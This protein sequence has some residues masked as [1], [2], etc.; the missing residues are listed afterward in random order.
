MND[1]KKL[2]LDN[3]MRSKNSPFNRTSTAA[4]QVNPNASEINPNSVSYSRLQTSARIF[5]AV[6]SLGGENV[7]T[8]GDIQVAINYASANGGGVV[9]LKAGTYVLT[10]N[11]TLT[12]NVTLLGEDRESTIISFGNA[13]SY[14]IV[15]KGTST[16]D[17]ITNVRLESLQIANFGTS[18]GS[19]GSAP[20]LIDYADNVK[21]VHCKFKT[22]YATVQT[23]ATVFASPHISSTIIVTDSVFDTCRQGVKISADPT[24]FLSKGNAIYVTGNTFT[25]ITEHCV[26]TSDMIE[27][28]I[29]DNLIDTAGGGIYISASGL[30]PIKEINVTDN[31]I[32]NINDTGVGSDGIIITNSGASLTYIVVSGN[33]IDTVAA[34]TGSH[35]CIF[36]TGSARCVITNNVCVAAD[37]N[38]I[39]LTTTDHCVVDGNI[40]TGNTGYGVTIT[41][42]GSDKN[43]VTSNSL[44]GNTAGGLND[45]GTS[46]TAANNITS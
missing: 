9:F 45:S 7:G 16:S 39:A 31:I 12:S 10:A 26:A 42:A 37:G 20:V 44:V 5:K 36:V 11:L 29:R 15:I 13:T 1:Y 43:I 46:T 30:T 19:A 18:G 3:W 27:V 33:V 34:A 28:F 41:D 32:R 6:V 21:I 22:N 24:D 25:S 17:L 2:G 14:S 40:A 8:F 23:G 38:G 4:W 35:N